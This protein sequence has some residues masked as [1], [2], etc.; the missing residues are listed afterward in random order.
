MPTKYKGNYGKMST[1]GGGGGGAV[2]SGLT[3]SS[4]TMGLGKGPGGNV[5]AAAGKKFKTSYSKRMGN[6]RRVYREGDTY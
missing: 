1:E 4:N 2:K 6:N 3:K 5:R